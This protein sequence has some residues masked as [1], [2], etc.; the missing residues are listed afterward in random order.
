MIRHEAA[1]GWGKTATVPARVARPTDAAALKSLLGDCARDGT[2]VALR[3][4]GNSYGDLITDTQGVIID[5]L[6]FGAIVDSDFERGT[7]TV[8]PGVALG[9]LVDH[10]LTEGWVPRAI[11]GSPFITVGGAIANDVH[12]KDAFNKGNFGDGVISMRIMLADGAVVTASHT[13]NAELFNGVIGGLG[14][15]GIVVEATLQLEKVPSGFLDVELVRFDDT[16]AMTQLFETAAHDWDMLVAWLDAF[17]ANGRGV[18]EKGRWRDTPAAA[19]AG[20]AMPARSTGTGFRRALGAVCRPFAGRWSFKLLNA[21]FF[22]AVPFVA[23]PKVKHFADFNFI[24]TS[25]I[26]EPPDL[27]PG[28]MIEVQVLIAKSDAAQTIRKLIGLC[29][30]HKQES[31]WCGVKLHKSSPTPL[32]FTGDG[33]SLSVNLPGRNTRE[34]GFAAFLGDLVQFVA[35]TG[36]RVYIGKDA[37]LRPDDIRTLFPDKD[38][39]VALKR[40]FDPDGL[41]QCDLA[42]RLDLK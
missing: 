35:G 3:G 17:D 23:K 24:V 2:P 6:A 20:S 36:G 28:G 12:G 4:G 8:E 33:Y 41:F 13:E 30:A 5:M 19:R 7:V 34:P 31:W 11:P 27:Y 42:R 26:P 9:Q 10:C 40:R 18:L 22:A 38:A 16:D 37:V 32:G 29:K 25:R 15:F 1:S 21:L 14:L 39:F